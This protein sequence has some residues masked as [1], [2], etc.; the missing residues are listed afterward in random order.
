MGFWDSLGKIAGEIVE[1]GVN[2]L[3]KT[4]GDLRNIR[5]EME[6]YSESELVSAYKS[7]RRRGD[8]KVS[9]TAK[10]LLKENY[11]Y[12]DWEIDRLEF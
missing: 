12:E 1:K 10:R 2:D 7:A 6:N 4:A 8:Y 9:S 3:K 11:D 5:E